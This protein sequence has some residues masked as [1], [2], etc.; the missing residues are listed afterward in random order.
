ME[1]AYPVQ[2]ALRPL[3][4]NTHHEWTSYSAIVVRKLLLAMEDIFKF[5]GEKLNQATA[6]ELLVE[7]EPALAL[8]KAVQATRYFSKGSGGDENSHLRSATLGRAG[9]TPYL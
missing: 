9:P 8:N 4:G 7:K 2:L 5:I 6:L 1:Q 3:L